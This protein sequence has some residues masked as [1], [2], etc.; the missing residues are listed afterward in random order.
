MKGFHFLMGMI[1]FNMSVSIFNMFGIWNIGYTGSNISFGFNAITAILGALA[2]ATAAGILFP[3]AEKNVVY[4]IILPAFIVLWTNTSLIFSSFGFQIDAATGTNH[5]TLLILG[6][7]SI[8]IIM[9]IIGVVQM[10]T[11]GWQSYE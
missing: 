4:M 8:G 3:H 11:G 5:G 6:F 10:S 9:F 7:L 1:L 2:I